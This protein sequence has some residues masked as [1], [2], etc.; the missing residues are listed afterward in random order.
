ML[1]LP[2]FAPW[3]VPSLDQGGAEFMHGVSLTREGRVRSTVVYL[4]CTERQHTRMRPL[5]RRIHEHRVTTQSQIGLC[6]GLRASS[7]ASWLRVLKPHRQLGRAVRACARLAVVER[8][9][10]ART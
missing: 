8:W 5:S 10:D 6:Y 1:R 3:L 2:E 4:Q 9:S 7:W